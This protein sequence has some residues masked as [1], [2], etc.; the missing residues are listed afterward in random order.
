MSNT[1][2]DALEAIREAN[3]SS[4]VQAPLGT[5]TRAACRQLAAACGVP[6]DTA[7]LISD[8]DLVALYAVARKNETSAELV[9]AR[10]AKKYAGLSLIGEM[11]A[12]EGEETPTAPGIALEQVQELINAAL[13]DVPETARKEARAV[14]EEHKPVNLVVTMPQAANPVAVG[15][16]H[17]RMGDILKALAAGL[18]VYLHGPAGSGKTT[19]AT[20]CAEALEVQFYFAAK[21]ESE[22]LL[23]GFKDARGE[24]VRTQFREA[25]EHG[26]VF[27]F[28]ELDGSSPG[29]VVALNA[30]LANGVCPFP[31][32]I[33]KRHD[34]FY[35]I[36][37][38]NT[39]LNGANRQYTGRVQLD[40]A[41]VD[42][43][44]FIEFGYDNALEMELASDKSWCKHVQSVRQAIA[45]RGLTYLVTPRATIDGC[46]ALAAGFSWE[47]CEAMTIFKGL[48]A[49]TVEQIKAALVPAKPVEP[50][51]I[52]VTRAEP[53]DPWS[54]PLG[55]SAE[56]QYRMMQ[57]A[58]RQASKAGNDQQLERFIREVER[59]ERQRGG[60]KYGYNLSGKRLISE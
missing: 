2:A 43:F 44:A 32:G 41:S 37:A 38:G 20:K 45:D 40:A 26:G 16:V 57:E 46:K 30:A 11:P 47:D 39:K 53:F 51:I 13:A 17:H 36:A 23:L 3:G 50:E 59:M 58:M 29:A 15:L 34:K 14:I 60:S 28:D 27:L 24:V 18:N 22:Y 35:C 6:F 52:P 31:D 55:G 8:K 10:I 5:Q 42:R 48:D 49:E 1:I 9:A 7:A 21:V 54:N 12:P 19:A 33:V 56:Q 25:Y 4:L